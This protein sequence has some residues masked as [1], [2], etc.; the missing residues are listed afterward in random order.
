MGEDFLPRWQSAEEESVTLRRIRF[1]NEIEDY[2]GVIMFLL[3]MA[4]FVIWFLPFFVKGNGYTQLQMVQ[5]LKWADFFLEF[6]FLV[7]LYLVVRADRRGNAFQAL[8]E[9]F[10]LVLALF[11]E[12]PGLISFGYALI[13][14]KLIR[15]ARWVVVVGVLG[16]RVASPL[17]SWLLFS[18]HPPHRHP[19]ATPP[20]PLLPS[21]LDKVLHR[22]HGQPPADVCRCRHLHR[23]LPRLDRDQDPR[24]KPQRQPVVGGLWHR[25]L[26]WIRVHHDAR[27]R[28]L[29]STAQHL[30]AP[31]RG[32]HA[33]R[34][35]SRLDD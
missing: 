11:T 22:R 30:K 26:V 6:I 33:R 2:V 5:Y 32:R 12:V 17:F 10:H 28:R 19:T 24:A 20:Q 29:L 4:S 35:R 9:N 8:L 13:V 27:P 15:M 18:S 7:E 21:H 3:D 1:L 31:H 16:Y 34:D 25:R 14:I 23:H